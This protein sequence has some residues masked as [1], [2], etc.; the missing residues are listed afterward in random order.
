LVSRLFRRHPQIVFSRPYHAIIDDSVQNILTKESHWQIVTLN[1]LAVLHFGYQKEVIN[2]QNKYTRSKE[3]MEGFFKTHP[4]DPY[5]CNKLGALYVQMGQIPRGIKLLK[6][7]LKAKN[8][9][10]PVL[11]E[12]HYHL[13]NAYNRLQSFQEAIQHYQQAIA[14]PVFPL[15][16]LGS[17]N[18]LA[19]LYNSLGQLE[20][21][22]KLYQT[23]ISLDPNFAL[24]YYNLGMTLKA[25]GR[26]TEAIAAYSQAIQL[27]PNYPFAYQ[28]LAVVFLKIG[29]VPESLAAFE[30]AIALHQ[31]QNNFT[32]V[33]KI[34]QGLQELGFL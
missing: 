10:I 12:L 29:K 1:S 11:Y 28:N 23:V 27:N 20:T 3:V 9:E 31:S 5:V 33:N 32:E 30:Q 2:S 19:G 13:A 22:C 18:N 24:G 4:D 34:L 15:L 8:K 21:A 14:L 17:Y 25:L 26:Y 7:G 16:K 6:R